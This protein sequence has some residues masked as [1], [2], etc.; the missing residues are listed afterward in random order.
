MPGQPLSSLFTTWWKNSQDFSDTVPLA[1]SME[2]LVPSLGNVQ[3][4]NLTLEEKGI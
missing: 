1:A 2:A 3:L 4:E